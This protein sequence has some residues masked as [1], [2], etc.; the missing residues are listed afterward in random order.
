MAEAE[1]VTIAEVREWCTLALDIL[2]QGG[3]E[4][5]KLDRDYHW[6]IAFTEAFKPYETPIPTM[7]SIADDVEELRSSMVAL[8]SGDGDSPWHVLDH[9]SGVITLLASEALENAGFVEK[10]IR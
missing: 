4:R 8:D 3:V 1:S 7:G 10:R 5:V 9:L 6:Q 2:E